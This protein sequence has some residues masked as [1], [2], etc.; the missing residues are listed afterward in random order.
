MDNGAVRLPLDVCDSS[1]HA[2][3]NTSVHQHAAVPQTSALKR[4]PPGSG[5][6]P[7]Q[8]AHVRLRLLT[9]HARFVACL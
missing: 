1:L 8:L 7:D 6:L 3:Q 2:A 9:L 4:P 5:D